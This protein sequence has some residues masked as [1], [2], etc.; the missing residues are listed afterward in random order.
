LEEVVRLDRDQ[1]TPFD[2]MASSNGRTVGGHVDRFP[3]LGLPNPDLPWSNGV[4]RLQC[5]LDN[6]FYLPVGRSPN[7]VVTGCK[8]NTGL[9]VI[10]PDGED[11]IPA[12]IRELR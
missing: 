11:D 12:A 9:S 5:A 10:A 1:A 8:A 6:K 2:R 4:L 3:P 7:E